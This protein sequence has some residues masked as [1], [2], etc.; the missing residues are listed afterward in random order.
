M[1]ALDLFSPPQAHA[2][3]RFLNPYEGTYVVQIGIST[4]QESANSLA[5][6]VNERDRTIRAFVES[7]DGRYVVQ[8]TTLLSLKDALALRERIKDSMPFVT[9]ADVVENPIK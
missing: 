7:R 3:G 1:N 5:S 9:R 6:R 8:V 4:S 2:Q